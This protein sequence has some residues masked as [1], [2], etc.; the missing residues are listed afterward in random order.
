VTPELVNYDGNNPYG[1]AAK[2]IYRE[3][4]TEVGSVGY[5]NAFGLYDMHGNVWE[6]CL[7][8]WHENYSGA[9]TDGG[10]WQSGGDSSLRVLRGGSWRSNA[11]RCRSADRLRNT[12]DYRYTFIG[13]RV[14]VG[15][16]TP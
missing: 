9:P 12:P 8:Y 11:G 7:D 2:G 3:T 1:S 6:W 13:F 5:P 14:V 10:S 4:T 15:A 16:R